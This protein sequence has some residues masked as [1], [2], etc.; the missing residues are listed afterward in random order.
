M[1]FEIEKG[2]LVG[3]IW[4]NGAGKS[5]TVKILSRILVPDSGTVS[6]GGRMLWIERKA[7]VAHIGVV[8]GQRTQL[9]WDEPTIGLAF[10]VLAAAALAAW[11]AAG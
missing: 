2:K 3:Y 4:P 5:T 11:T 7:Y 6:V 1:S 9:W 10:L 8:F